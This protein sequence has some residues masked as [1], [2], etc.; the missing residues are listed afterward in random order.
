MQL[1]ASEVDDPCEPRRVI[2][3]DFFSLTARRERQRN[4]SQPLG[5]L[6]GRALLIKRFG[7]G[8]V[9]KALENKRTIPN[10]GK[11]AR[12]DR[13]VVTHQIEF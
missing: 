1:D 10:S 8:A 4:G 12:R 3:Y 11:S 5:T 13:Q 7:F 2:D 6:F 9:D